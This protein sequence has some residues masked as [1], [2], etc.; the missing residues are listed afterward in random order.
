MCLFRIIGTINIFS[1]ESW[2]PET[3]RTN[4]DWSEITAQI[5]RLIWALSGR[6]WYKNRFSRSA[7]VWYITFCE[8]Y[9]TGSEERYMRPY[10]AKGRPI[11]PKGCSLSKDLP[12]EILALWSPSEQPTQTLKWTAMV[13]S[14][15]RFFSARECIKVVFHDPTQHSW[16]GTGVSKWSKTLVPVPSWSISHTEVFFFFAVW[17]FYAKAYENTSS[18]ISILSLQQYLLFYLWD[19]FIDQDFNSASLRG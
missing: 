6:S 12:K 14:L 5:R 18:R 19:Q 16:P 10:S 4:S 7:R 2:R 13:H 9:T 8:D 3:S 15:L 11:G 1:K 17:W